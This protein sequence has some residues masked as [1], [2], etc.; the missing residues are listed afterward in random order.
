MTLNSASNNVGL[1]TCFGC[2]AMPTNNLRLL[3][4]FFVRTTHVKRQAMDH[5]LNN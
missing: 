1:E 4:M 2:K 5:V 3:L